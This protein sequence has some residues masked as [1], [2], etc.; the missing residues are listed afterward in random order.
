M[1]CIGTKASS[2]MLAHARHR[3]YGMP[4]TISNCSNNYGPHQYVE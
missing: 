4:V 2:D 3:T 1:A